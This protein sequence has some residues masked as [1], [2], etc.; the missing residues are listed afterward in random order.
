MNPTRRSFLS[1][2]AALPLARAQASLPPPNIIFILADDL[3]WGDPACYGNPYIKTPN[4][5]RLAREGS[6]FTQF[7]VNSPVCSPSRTAFMT[8]QYP[9]H[10]R[11]HGHLAAPELNARRDMPDFLDPNVVMLP[12][13][14]Q[15]AGYATAAI[16]KWHL[17]SGPGAPPPREYG[18]DFVRTH[19][20]NDT[21][22]AA[23]VKSDP[24]FW[25][26]CTP[27]IVDETLRFIE[28]N[29]Q[30]PFYANVWTTLPHAPLHP[31]DE[32]MAPYR[33]F[34]PQQ[35]APY[36]GAREIYYASVT[37]LDRELGRLFDKLDKWGLAGNTL[38]VFSSD[39]G[40]E[41]IF[42]ANA[43][44]SGVGSPGPFRGRKR[45]LYE[46][47]VRV[48]FLVRWPKRVPARRVDNDSVITAVDF[49]PTMARLAGAE[50][51]SGWRLDGEDR[52]GALLGTSSKRTKP[53]LWEW[54]FNVAAHPWNRSPILSIRDGDWKLLMNPDRSRV[55]LYDIP[56][57]PVEQNNLADRNPAVVRRLSETVLAWQKKLPAG[58]MDP[59][60]GRNDY[61]WPGTK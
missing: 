37:H 56:R 14:L 48:P 55:E 45:S 29:R 41:D 58:M 8:G 30:R 12:R 23:R 24:Y 60:A 40:P 2:L 17:G 6:L 10:H 39:N 33:R 49:L 38:L 4:L 46:G 47:G 27:L 44:H 53:I 21:S 51:P 43:G 15:K 7:Y 11:I 3:G 20:S 50:P 42:I 57:D 54:R 25:A 16:G 1:G 22:W 19:V 36:R 34:G 18:F 31:A 5:D 9:A 35:A 59:G 26:R 52:S 32:D 13:L 28:H 61:P